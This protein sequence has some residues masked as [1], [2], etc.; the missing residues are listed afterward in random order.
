MINQADYNLRICPKRYF[1]FSQGIS[2]N[3]DY[4]ENADNN[5]WSYKG[6]VRTLE[7]VALVRLLCVNRLGKEEKFKKRLESE[8]PGARCIVLKKEGEIEIA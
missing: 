5:N 3:R 2:A 8:I 4:K 7:I 1:S 6:I